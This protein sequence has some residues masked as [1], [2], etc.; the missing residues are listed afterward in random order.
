MLPHYEE[1]KTF[2]KN[3]GKGVQVGRLKK[4]HL[5]EANVLKMD[6]EELKSFFNYSLITCWALKSILKSYLLWVKSEYNEDTKEVL[7]L[8]SQIDST[9]DYSTQ[10]F[11]SLS[12]LL[13]ETQKVE[14][15]TLDLASL[16]NPDAQSKIYDVFIRLKAS[17]ILLWCGVDFEGMTTIYASNIT[18]NGVFVPAWNKEVV[19]DKKEAVSRSIKILHEANNNSYTSKDGCNNLF[20][21]NSVKVIKNLPFLA[22]GGSCPDHRFY[23]VNIMN[24]GNYERFALWETENNRPLMCL[25][26]DIIYELSRGHIAKGQTSAKLADYHKFLSSI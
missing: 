15:E 7:Y 3:K 19:I 4:I 24:A 2:C 13:D 10:Y 23:K 20:N 11:R 12:D 1:F 25:D 5:A 14:D 16:S 21:T 22:F 26:K 18:E 8:L 9:T 17:Y 6:E